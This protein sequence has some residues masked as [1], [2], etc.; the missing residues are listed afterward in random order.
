V[1]NEFLMCALLRTGTNGLE[2]PRSPL[3][4]PAIWTTLAIRQRQLH[5]EDKSCGIQPA[6]IRVIYR[7][8]DCSCPSQGAHHHLRKSKPPGPLLTGL[9]HIRGDISEGITNKIQT[10]E[11]VMLSDNYRD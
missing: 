8:F 7:R 11:K 2:N 9:L 3:E 1:K 5:D 6:Y 10:D 4:A